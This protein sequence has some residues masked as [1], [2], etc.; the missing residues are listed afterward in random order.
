MRGAA[1]GQRTDLIEEQRKSLKAFSRLQTQ[2]PEGARQGFVISEA[3][4]VW[5]TLG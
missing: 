2:I 4:R 5:Y 3:G 1:M